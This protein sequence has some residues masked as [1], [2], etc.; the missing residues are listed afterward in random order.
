LVE[1]VYP[2]QVVVG[3]ETGAEGT[4]LARLWTLTLRRQVLIAQQP[5]CQRRE[6]DASDAL[7]AQHVEQA[8]FYP[9]VEQRVRGLVDEA[10]HAHLAQQRHCLSR[11]LWRVRRDAGVER[12]A[13]L[14]RRGE[15]AHGLLEG[16]VRIEAVRG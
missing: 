4:V 1:G 14:H 13:L 6:G 8:A 5:L 3:E 11:S 9:A 15:G 10:R 2:P 7:I 12:L 16:R